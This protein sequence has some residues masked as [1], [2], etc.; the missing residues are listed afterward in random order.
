MVSCLGQ[1]SPARKA[2]GLCETVESVLAYLAMVIF[3]KISPLIPHSVVLVIDG[4]VEVT[5]LIYKLPLTA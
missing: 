4:C 1:G 2:L 5:G 3:L